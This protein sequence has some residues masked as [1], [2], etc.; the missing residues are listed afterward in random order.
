M[1]EQPESEVYWVY[2]VEQGLAKRHV[3]HTQL[4]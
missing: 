3:V 4:V 2:S 1:T